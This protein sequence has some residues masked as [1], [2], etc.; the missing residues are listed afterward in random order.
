MARSKYS[1]SLLKTINREKTKLL[2]S[3]STVLSIIKKS[4]IMLMKAKRGKLS[5]H[6]QYLSGLVFFVLIYLSTP[7]SRMTVVSNSRRVLISV[8]SGR[9]GLSRESGTMDS[10]MAFA[11]LTVNFRGGSLRSR[12]ARNMEGPR[13]ARLERAGKEC[14][15]SICIMGIA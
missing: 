6:N 13:G 1:L 4:R 2:T 5:L 10:P 7:K 15:L 11:S 8:S 12:T 14:L 9:N 3:R